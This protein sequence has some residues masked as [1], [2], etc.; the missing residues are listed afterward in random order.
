MV[1]FQQAF[2]LSRFQACHRSFGATCWFPPSSYRLLALSRFGLCRS[3]ARRETPAADRTG[4]GT[5]R[6]RSREYRSGG[7]RRLSSDGRTCAVGC[8]LRCGGTDTGG[9]RVHRDRTCPCDHL[10][11]AI[12]CLS[13]AGDACGDPSLSPSCHLSTSRSFV[14]PGHSQSRIS[15]PS[16]R[17]SSLPLAWESKRV[18][19]LALCFRS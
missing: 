15:Q 13:A 12:D 4:P 17:P 2:H 11:D 8:E 5:Y 19:A 3:N 7:Y 16:P 1:L 18:S 14:A 10:P 9:R 6:T